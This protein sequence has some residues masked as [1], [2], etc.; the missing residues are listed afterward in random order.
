LAIIE[1]DQGNPTEARRLLQRSL[2]IKEDLG[3]QR[4]QAASLHQLS[5]I[6][7]AQGNPAEARR[8]LQ[9]SLKIKEDLG[10]QRGQ[11]TS[12]HQLAI[13]EHDQGNPAEARRLWEQ[14]LTIKA[15]IEDVA[16]QAAT[17]GMLAQLD[18]VDGAF[19]MARTRAQRAVQLLERIGAADAA[20]ARSILLD[21]EARAG[22]GGAAA[23]PAVADWPSLLQ[24]AQAMPP[25]EVLPQFDRELVEATRTD[26]PARQVA[27]CLAR[28]VAL[29][30]SGDVA[31]CDGA[32][33]AAEQALARVAGTERAGLTELYTNLKGKR[34]AA[35]GARKAE[36]VRLHEEAS[37]RWEAGE[38]SEALAL[39]ERA[40]AA[41]VQEQS[42][43]NQAMCLWALG[44]TLLAMERPGEALGRLREGLEVATDLGDP[45]L[46]RA[47][48]EAAAEAMSAAALEESLQRP[49]DE[50]LAEAGSDERKAEAL[51]VRATGL[52]RRGATE[53]TA[54]IDQALDLAR[55]AGAPRLCVAG[56]RLRGE[57]AA[58]DGRTT[59]ARQH[60]AAALRL[61]EEAQLHEEASALAQRI[62]A[63][64]HPVR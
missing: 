25:S 32:L 55:R 28:S 53:A 29:W 8:L 36:S 5:I 62:A 18:A 56:H 63:L 14:S 7:R 2:K 37:A 54:L 49:L 51:L 46:L 16:G 44:Q 12:L 48:R 43:H 13:I 59:E 39:F 17:L 57:I 30:R 23:G 31:G 41:S 40:L 10:D 4:G 38:Q 60:L 9:R 26:Q 61:A 15:G 58:G 1:H 33:Q 22:E 11:A 20:T 6:E 47:M 21:I 52:A 34:A 42:K 19:E 27:L 3:D 24:R 35:T 45:D 64:E 50:V